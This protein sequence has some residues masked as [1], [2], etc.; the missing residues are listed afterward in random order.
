MRRETQINLLFL[1]R[2]MCRIYSAAT[3]CVQKSRGLIAIRTTA[4]AAAAC[5][6]DAISRVVASDDPSPFALHYS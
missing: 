1:L 5:V 6:G 2:R 3:E 4:F